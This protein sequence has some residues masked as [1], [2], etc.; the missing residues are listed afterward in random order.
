MLPGT[1]VILGNGKLGKVSPIDD[2]ISALIVNGVAV[3]GQFALGDV[4]GPFLQPEDAIAKGITSAYDATNDVNAYKHIADFYNE[5]PL[6]TKLYVMVVAKTQTMTTTC[7]LATTLGLKKLL[8]AGAGKIKLVGISYSP[9]VSY[10][11]TFTSQLETD[12]TTALV[13]L[14]LTWADEFTYK[15]PFRALLWLFVDGVGERGN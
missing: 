7:T 15:R 12:L 5:A 10:T 1:E 6:G 13:Q 14:K 3:G 8:V 4:L 2:G 11:P 9:D